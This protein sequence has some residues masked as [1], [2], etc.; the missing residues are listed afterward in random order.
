MQEDLSILIIS[1][2]KETQHFKAGAITVE[3]FIIAAVVVIVTMP[4][5]VF[6]VIP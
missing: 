1:S 4:R 5:V 2:I 3:Y 6:G